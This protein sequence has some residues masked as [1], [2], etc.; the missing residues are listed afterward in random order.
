MHSGP[1]C[2]VCRHEQRDAIEAALLRGESL[3]GIARLR[4][5]SRDTIRHHRD[6]CI[7]ETLARSR[8]GEALKRG[9]RLLEQAA[10]L[11]DEYHAVM[12]R[13]KQASER[14]RAALLQ[15]FP[16]DLRPAVVDAVQALAVN[17]HMILRA[18]REAR[19]SLELLGK[20]AGQI[21]AEMAINLHAA[22]DFVEIRRA[23]IEALTPYPEAQQAAADAMLEFVARR[24]PPGED[25]PGAGALH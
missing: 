10:R 19:P 4:R 24:T 2:R 1:S 21:K 20:L 23:L 8:H 3:S 6:R 14:T 18:V 22:P 5:L 25:R 13:A 15:N 16:E 12:E 17:D 7:P 9:D 11:Y